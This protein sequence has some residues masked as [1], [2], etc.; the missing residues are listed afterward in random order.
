M[1][2][3]EELGVVFADGWRW[4]EYVFESVGLGE[5]RGDGERSGQLLRLCEQGENEDVRLADMAGKNKPSKGGSRVERVEEGGRE[6]QKA[7]GEVKREFLFLN[8]IPLLSFLGSR[9][10]PELDDKQAGAHRW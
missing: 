4:V 2:C 10:R 8:N 5:A 3:Q 7:L 1:V 9:E 6:P